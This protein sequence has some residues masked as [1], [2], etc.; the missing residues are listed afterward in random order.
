M[1]LST[2]V[3]VYSVRTI[4]L[5]TLFGL[6]TTISPKGIVWFLFLV[7]WPAWSAARALSLSFW[8]AVAAGVLSTLVMYVFEWVHQL[9]HS[10]AARRVG[11]P[12]I[13]V[14]WGWWL[15]NSVYPKDEPPL[16]PRT[17][18]R[19]ALGGFWINLLIGLALAPAAFYLWPRG[20]LWSWV[21]AFNSAWNLF[22]LG[23]GALTPIDIPGVFTIDGGTI[24]RYWRE[25]RRK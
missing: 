18:I 14:H 11:Y 24:W 3:P 10:L 12:M 9:G 2:F 8:E 22:V 7:P 23:L 4:T 17:H 1:Y 21:V 6:K 16:P 15:S 19:R 20:D 5:F 13:G 25:S